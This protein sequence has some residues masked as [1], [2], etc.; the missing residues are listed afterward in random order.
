MN[1]KERINPTTTTKIIPGL[2]P[3]VLISA[4]ALANMYLYIQECADEVGWLGTVEM[5]ES[6]KHFIIHEVFLFNQDVSSVTT[7]I[8]PEGL[9][10][11]AEEILQRPDGMEVWNSMKMWGHSHVNM[12]ITPSG[13]DDKQM[14]E[15][16]NIGHDYFIRLIGNKKGEMKLDFY[17]YKAGITYLDIPWERE[18][19]P[20]EVAISDEIFRLQQLL[21]ASTSGLVE[22]NKESVKNELTAKVKK[23]VYRAPAYTPPVTTRGA[24]TYNPAEGYWENGVYH[25]YA[26]LHPQKK[27]LTK[28][29]QKAL[30]K[31]KKKNERGGNTT[32]KDKKK[33]N[34]QMVMQDDET[35]FIFDNRFT[36][37][38]EVV[39]NFAIEELKYLSEARD[40][41]EL[42]MSLEELGY[43]DEFTINDIE[44]IF[45]VAYK[46]NP[47]QW[48]G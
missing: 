1:L 20:E 23:M 45:R 31:Q 12:G 7:E 17:D 10:S 11:F 9:S 37:D 4:E 43:E 39:E 25:E 44:R 27:T 2:T 41:D 6:G 13:Q 26:D 18:E 35:I 21:E 36:S 30:E 3:R 14:L 46:F 38:D 5:L 19:T 15:F 16:S 24:R 34:V 42:E 29:E 28:K 47:L 8:T 48:R 40:F 33:A 32:T 22:S